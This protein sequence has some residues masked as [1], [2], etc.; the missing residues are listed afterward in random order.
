[1]TISN[2]SVESLRQYIAKTATPFPML[3]DE[4]GEVIQRYGIKNNWELF[5]RGVPHPATYIIDRQGMVRFAE[6]RQNFLIRTKVSTIFDE[7]R[8]LAD[9]LSVA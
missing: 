5:H 9:D 7:L 1:M 4:R 2:D 6:V 3:S 8:K